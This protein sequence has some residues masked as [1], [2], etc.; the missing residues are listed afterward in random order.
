[1]LVRALFPYPKPSFASSAGE[2]NNRPAINA[3]ELEPVLQSLER[4]PG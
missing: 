4:R 1:V 3:D 2:P